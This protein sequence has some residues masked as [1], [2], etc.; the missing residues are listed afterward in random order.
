MNTSTAIRV[1]APFIFLG[2]MASGFGCYECA[3]GHSYR[4]AAESEVTT[5]GH[6]VQAPRSRKGTYRYEFSIKGVRMED[7]SNVCFTPLAPGA[8][9]NNGPV[10]V[11]YSY[12]P[13][14]NSLLEDFADAGSFSY[15]V[16]KFLLAIGLPPFVLCSA[17]L[18]LLLNRQ[19]K[20]LKGEP[21]SMHFIPGE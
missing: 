4:V 14:P 19:R 15:R 7:Y 1:L 10:L 2:A 21:D 13:S 8:C 16:G 5:V 12:Q 9:E 17:L 20:Q 3:E 11:Y 6:I 18:A